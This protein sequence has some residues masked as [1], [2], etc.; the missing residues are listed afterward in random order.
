[1]R[2]CSE[3]SELEFKLKSAPKKSPE[4]LKPWFQW[5]RKRK[6]RIIFGHWAALMG[7]TNDR[8]IIGL[9]TGYV[10]GNHL[11]LMNMDTNQRYCCDANKKITEYDELEFECL[12]KSGKLS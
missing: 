8:N 4:G 9:D 5:E 3:S 1:M 2:F 11:T 12:P 7:H 6:H 10:W